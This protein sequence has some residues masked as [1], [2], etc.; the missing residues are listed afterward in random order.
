MKQSKKLEKNY[1]VIVSEQA[2]YDL[3]EAAH[4]YHLQQNGLGA[5]FLLSIEDVL[6]SIKKFPGTFQIRFKDIRIAVIRK[7]PYLV[8]YRISSERNEIQII[9]NKYPY[10][11]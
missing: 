8:F 7:Y 10:E 6:Q 9:P 3:K 1:R 4:Y 11:G 2:Q 5:K